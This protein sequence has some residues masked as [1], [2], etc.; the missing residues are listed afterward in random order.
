MT[1]NKDDLHLV[2]VDLGN[3]YPIM[4]LEVADDQAEFAWTNSAPLAEAAYV[5]GFVPRA[6]YLGDEPIGLGLVGPFYPGYVYDGPPEPGAYIIDHVMVDRRYQGKGYGRRLVALLVDETSA[7]PDCR[8][9][10]LAVHPGNERALAM[11]RKMGFA[12]IGRT[13][14]KDILMELKTPAR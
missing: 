7:R 6:L 11:Y 5:P 10:L 14:E 8:R 12:D 2:D 3:Y 1:A 4:M 9:I 13:H